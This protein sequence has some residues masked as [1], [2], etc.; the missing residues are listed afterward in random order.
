MDIYYDSPEG[1]QITR[2][3]ALQELKKH[4]LNDESTIMVFDAEVQPNK[5]GYYNAQSVLQWLGY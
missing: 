2:K 1:E 4:Q 3:R 5:S